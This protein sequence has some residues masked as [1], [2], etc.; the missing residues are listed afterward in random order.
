V[1]YVD[2]GKYQFTTSADYTGFNPGN[3]TSVLSLGALRV[4]YFE[5][6][7]LVIDTS[8]LPGSS[9]LP[10]IV[11][12]TPILSGS[13]LTALSGSFP[14]AVTPGNTVAVG[15]ATLAIT[16]GANPAPSGMTLGGSADHFGQVVAAA[17]SASAAAPS[18]YMYA[19]PSAAGGSAALAI[20]MSGGSGA[21][22]TAAQGYEISGLLATS[23]ALAC[24]DVIGKFSGA[25]T[26]KTS[27]STAGPSTTA[28]NDMQLG[29]GLASDNDP[30]SLSQPG[31]QSTIGSFPLKPASAY[32]TAAGGAWNLASVKGSPGTYTL[33]ADDDCTWGMV[34]ASFLQAAD[35]G[36]A[37]AFP[38]TLAIDG[39]T[40]DSEATTPGTGYTYSLGQSPMYLN[41]GQNLQIFWSTLD[42]ATYA[43]YAQQLPIT[44]WFRYDPSV[45]PAS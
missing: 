41:T 23:S 30:F 12:Q 44:A 34:A 35:A 16:S 11:Q 24:V 43:Q 42:A 15:L 13:S 6:Y 22:L 32:Y 26:A 39:T 20:A 10:K 14:A 19:D 1:S 5:L 3:L 40:Y 31:W 33:N 2:L 29:F 21:V 27:E 36:Q 7:R 45:Q 37:E 28:A 38:F 17:G 4:P 8:Q 18:A 25:Q 9:S